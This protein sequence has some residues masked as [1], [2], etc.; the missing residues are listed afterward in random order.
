MILGKNDSW[1]KMIF[2]EGND[3]YEKIYTPEN[4]FDLKVFCVHPKQLQRDNYRVSH[5]ILDRLKL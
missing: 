3:F 4:N 5:I 2:K 1:E